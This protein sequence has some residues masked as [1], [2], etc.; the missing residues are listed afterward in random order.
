[1]QIYDI[2]ELMDDRTSGMVTAGRLLELQEE[3]VAPERAV[4]I[5]QAYGSA[6]MLIGS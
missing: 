1:M 4:L 2:P 6:T 5:D 3:V